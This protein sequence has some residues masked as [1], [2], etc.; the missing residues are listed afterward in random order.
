MPATLSYVTVDE[1]Q[2]TNAAQYELMHLLAKEH[3]NVCV[4]GDDDHLRLA[5]G[6]D[7]QY[8]RFGESYPEVKVIKL[9]Q[10]YRSTRVILDAANSVIKNNPQRRPKQLWS[11]KGQGEM[12]R[13]QSFEDEEQEAEAIVE[14][15]S[16]VWE[17]GFLG[18]N[19]PF[20]FVRTSRPGRW[21][22]RCARQVRYNL[23]GAR[24]F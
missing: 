14:V 22:R 9:E 12:I 24:A 8:S 17:N 10:N 20:S 21:R 15:E 23:I 1:Y 7:F 13:L 2:D 3:R 19:T 4:V 6:G 5:R 11:A 16:T 18:R